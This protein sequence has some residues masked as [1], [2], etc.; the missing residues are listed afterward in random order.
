[1]PTAASCR[2]RPGSFAVRSLLSAVLLLGAAACMPAGSHVALP[3]GQSLD[4][5]IRTAMAHDDAMAWSAVRPLAWSDFRGT[6]P[7]SGQEGALTAYSIFYGVRCVRE[8][9]AARVTAAF[10]PRQSW[11][12]PEVLADAGLKV[13]TLRHEQTHFNLTEVH[14]RRMRRYFAE[15]Y[16]PCGQTDSQLQ[17]SAEEFVHE[18]VADQAKYD[19][20]TSHGLNRPRQ[21]AWDRDVDQMLASLDRYR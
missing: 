4:Q 18:E 7:V 11:V 19:G 21:A 9:F 3:L 1:M 12:R 14:A 6:A 2:N 8:T 15:L 5:D 17:T 10:L 16:N 13:R 20:E